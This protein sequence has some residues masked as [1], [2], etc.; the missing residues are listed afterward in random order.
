[1]TQFKTIALVFA[2]VLATSGC[3]TSRT[4]GATPPGEPRTMVRAGAVEPSRL[5]R[6][7]A[8]LL[9]P[10]GK[11]VLVVAHRADWKR[12]PENSLAAIR[13]CIEL[14]VDIVEID[15]RRTRDGH[16]V[17][18]HD[19]TVDR[20]T[21]GRGKVSD[22]TLAQVRALRLKMSSGRLTGQRVP[23]LEQAMGLVKG[24]CMVNLDKAYDHSEQV[25]RVLL[26]TNTVD[27]AIFKGNASPAAVQALLQ[28]LMPRPL[29]MPVV[30]REQTD[31]ARL[32]DS[33][34]RA[35]Y[36]Y[37]ARLKPPAVEIIFG[38]D[39][40]PIISARA[41]ARMRE[42]GARV[43]VNTLWDGHLAGGHAD[44]KAARDPDAVWGW[45]LRRGVNIIQTDELDLL[46]AYLRKKG[47][48]W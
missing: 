4:G 12:A 46:L 22:L 2:A 19:E 31:V 28:K 16:L 29:Y 48:H 7:R 25:H 40:D 26:R 3:A 42:G 24:R 34:A 32:D 1:M 15:V 39:A 18:M 8:E 35:V 21:N 44:E 47:R 36:G 14:G 6:I 30:G 45:L 9:N 17:L 5:A 23:T 43:W 33:T 20:T 38:H 41:V 13:S 11:M 37:L 10:R 27:H